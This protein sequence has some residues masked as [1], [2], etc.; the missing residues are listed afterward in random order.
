MASMKV[1]DC[2]ELD[3]PGDERHLKEMY[4]AA[5][6][7]CDDVTSIKTYVD[8]ESPYSVV[9][10]FTMTKKNQNDVSDKIM[11]TFAESMPNYQNQW[12]AFP[13]SEAEERKAQKASE[14]AKAKRKQAREQAKQGIGT[15]EIIFSGS[16]DK[17]TNSQRAFLK[18]KKEVERYQRTLHE[19]T[20]KYETL[21]LYYSEIAAPTLQAISEL[22]KA[23]I[24]QAAGVLFSTAR[25]PRKKLRGCLANFIFHHFGALAEAG[26]ILDESM[27][28]LQKKTVDLLHADMHGKGKSRTDPKSG[29]GDDHDAFEILKE[30]MQ[31]YFFAETGETI[32]LDGLNSEMCEEEIMDYIHN[33]MYGHP[34]NPDNRKQTK[35]QH[36]RDE[37]EQQTA[38]AHSKNLTSVYRQLA[39]MF[40]PDLEQDP[41]LKVEKEA[42]MKEL[43][44]AYDKGDLYT[45]LGLELRW[46]QKNDG[47]IT[48]MTDT[49]LNAYTHALNQQCQ[50]IREEISSVKRNPRYA[51][52]T[53][54]G[55]RDFCS[56]STLRRA[57][58]E[59]AEDLKDKEKT[60]KIDFARFKKIIKKPESTA[61][62]R[63]L[64]AFMIEEY[65]FDDDD[66]DDEALLFNLFN[67]F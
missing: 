44:A 19:W 15:V 34:A 12:I 25:K 27:R 35:K 41:Q 56:V 7:L 46:L 33:K 36:V 61:R 2:I 43:T 58:R 11:H 54:I 5:E 9:A 39:R 55:T 4:D 16:K 29:L 65:D 42:I 3:V 52:L 53:F 10:E 8:P 22:R 50:D 28:D 62:T 51:R 63:D 18:A 57:V 66:D 1:I 6:V 13:R 32:D 37:R 40:H 31:A 48:K 64:Q 14:R 20:E 47:D 17:L 45:I 60:M 38:E 30:T 49:K 24:E 26:Y 21:L 67:D 23:F 59:E